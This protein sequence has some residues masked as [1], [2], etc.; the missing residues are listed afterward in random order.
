MHV[1]SDAS[2]TLLEGHKNRGKQAMDEIGILPKAQG[3]IVNDRNT[4][5]SG[6]T[7]AAHALCNAHILRELKSIE[8]QIP[9]AGEIKKCL[10]KAKY[11]KD[12]G[13]L[14]DKKGK[15]LQTEYDDI[16]RAQRH[17]YQKIEITLKRK[18]NKAGRIK[19]STDHNLF[20]ALKKKSHE[21]LKFM[22]LQE[23]PFD[24]NQAERDLWMLKVKMKNSNQFI[25]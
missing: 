25:E 19:R 15:K 13:A 17:H 22:Y 21:V 11:Y 12:S 1:Y 3:T 7:Q 8:A 24:N 9:W 20:Y 6:H 14:D 16:L 5:Y 10:L 18:K 2:N 23:V 4:S